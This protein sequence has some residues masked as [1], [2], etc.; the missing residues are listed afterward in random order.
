[1][2]KY[3]ILKQITIAL[4]CFGVPFGVFSGAM[5]AM[6]DYWNFI[7]GIAISMGF[8]FI[9]AQLWWFTMEKLGNKEETKYSLIQIQLA[10]QKLKNYNAWRQI[11]L[12]NMC[13]PPR[14]V[15]FYLT[16]KDN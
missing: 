4:Q 14:D 15:E 12:S 1:M 9:Q 13:A 7:L 6:G 2:N 10:E 5:L 11:S 3:K 8:T 16:N